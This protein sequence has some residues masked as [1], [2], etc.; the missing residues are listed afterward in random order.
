MEVD[1]SCAL[2]IGIPLREFLKYPFLDGNPS[3]S[4]GAELGK[5]NAAE[6]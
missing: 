2:V 5:Q 3:L 4:Q 6:Y 1:A